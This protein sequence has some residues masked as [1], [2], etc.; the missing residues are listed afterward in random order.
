MSMSQHSLKTLENQP[1]YWI[2]QEDDESNEARWIP[3]GDEE[4]DD[5]GEESEDESLPSIPSEDEH[6]TVCLLRYC[7]VCDDAFSYAVGREGKSM[8]L[9]PKS[10][11]SRSMCSSSCRKRQV[12]TLEKYVASKQVSFI[13]GWSRFA[14][15][16]SLIRKSSKKCLWKHTGN[17]LDTSFAKVCAV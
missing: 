17:D 6:E 9:I 15:L 7:F 8:W 13:D 3:I 11:R 10:M 5:E 1:N 12:V 4:S 14:E 16:L 2:Q